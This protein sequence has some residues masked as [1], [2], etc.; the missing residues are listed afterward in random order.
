[1]RPAFE[2]TN[3]GRLIERV[4]HEEPAR[5]RKLDSHI[6]RDLETIVLKAIAKDPADRYA[7][8]EALA[9]DLR[10]FVADRPILARRASLKERAWRWCRRNPALATASGLA[11]AALAAVAVVSISFGIYQSGTAADLRRALGE[12]EEAA[13]RLIKALGEK[14]EAVKSLG[15]AL[16]E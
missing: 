10:R 11:A 5:L 8:A 4:L 13:N 16:G 2:D 6:P 14:D 9:E 3:K 12:K 15:K 7:T 1:L